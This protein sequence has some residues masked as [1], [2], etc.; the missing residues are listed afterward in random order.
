MINDFFNSYMKFAGL[1]LFSD[2]Q[3]NWW[4]SFMKLFLMPFEIRDAMSFL[5]LIWRNTTCQILLSHYSGQSSDLCSACI[6]W[7]SEHICQEAADTDA[8][9]KPC[10]S[11]ASEACQTQTSKTGFRRR[12]ILKSQLCR[13][14]ALRRRSVPSLR[15]RG[16]A[17]EKREVGEKRAHLHRKR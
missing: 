13:V 6:A 3:R 15:W 14:D 10:I 4:K 11:F 12:A 8:L 16:R 7:C 1:C 5:E 17:L 9:R 2:M